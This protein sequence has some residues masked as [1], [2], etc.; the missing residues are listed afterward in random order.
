MFTCAV[1]H[2]VCARALKD[3]WKMNTVKM[4]IMDFSSLCVCVCVC[5]DRLIFGSCFFPW[6]FWNALVDI[7]RCLR[8][9]RHKGTLCVFP[10]SASCSSHPCVFLC[11]ADVA[12]MTAG[13]GVAQLGTVLWR[14]LSI[15]VGAVLLAAQQAHHLLSVRA[16]WNKGVE[17]HGRQTWNY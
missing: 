6:V 16:K 13:C 2:L 7:D 5:Q 15:P 17:I 12:G 10:V 4:L 9:C 3:G 11:R 8:R 14:L 1:S